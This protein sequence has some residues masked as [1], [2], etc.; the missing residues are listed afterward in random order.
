MHCCVF[1]EMWRCERLTW[2]ERGG[3][4]M[5]FIDVRTSIIYVNTSIMYL[6]RF[7]IYFLY[8]PENFLYKMGCRPYMHVILYR[9]AV[10][11]HF[12]VLQN[13][14][15]T[16]FVKQVQNLDTYILYTHWFSIPFCRFCSHVFFSH[17]CAHFW[18]WWRLHLC[19]QNGM[20]WVSGLQNGW[21]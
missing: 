8:P 4:G 11:K 12:Y 13:W 14:L 10:V 21:T 20:C 2:W 15:G 19:L 7:H 6:H 5:A 18:W 17:V 9:E 3:F 16:I 1:V